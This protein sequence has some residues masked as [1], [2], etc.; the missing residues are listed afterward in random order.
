MAK[1]LSREIA[2]R[3]GASA[4]EPDIADNFCPLAEGKTVSKE[5]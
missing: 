4:M 2:R 3:P 5:T 1:S